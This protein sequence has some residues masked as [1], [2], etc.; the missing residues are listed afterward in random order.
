MRLCIYYGQLNKATIKNHYLLLCI[1]DMLDQLRGATVFSEIELTSGYHQ[2]P[3]KKDIP[4]TTIWTRYG[5]YEFTVMPSGL[6]NAPAI[7]INLMNN[8]FRPYLDQFVVVF[9]NILVNSKIPEEH[10]S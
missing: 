4:K 9:I 6:A 2:I 8:I 3:V 1:D 10:A 5:H 7:F